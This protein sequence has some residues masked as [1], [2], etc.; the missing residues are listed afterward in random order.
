MPF[1]RALSKRRIPVVLSQDDVRMLLGQMQGRARMMASLMYGT[2]MRVM[3]CVR[4]RVQDID[5]DF[6]Q[7]AIR[8]LK[9]GK[10]RVIP[11]PGRLVAPLWKHLAETRVVHTDDLAAG[12]GEVLLPIALARKLSKAATDWRWQ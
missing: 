8:E 11:L 10:D 6:R 4:L 5:C 3:E 12:H 7:I 2:G 1:T 9:G